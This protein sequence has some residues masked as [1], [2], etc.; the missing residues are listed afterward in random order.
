LL[1]LHFI[2][3]DTAIASIRVI[4]TRC[5]LDF[6]SLHFSQTLFLFFAAG[7]AG[8]LNA[9]AGGGSFI[10]FP[11]LLFVGV[12]PVQANATNTVALWPGLAASTVAYIKRLDAPPRLLIPLLVTS[13]A[14]G[15]GGALL[16]LK[17]PQ[18]TFLHFVPWLILSGTLLFAFGNMIRTI[19][20]TSAMIDDLW[21][22]S[23]RAITVSSFVELLVATYGGYFGAGIGFITLGMLAALGMRDIN[24]MGAIRTLLAAAINA[25]AVVTF[26]LAGAVWWQD[27]AVMVAGALLG[28]WF[29]AHYAQK[30]DPRKVRAFVIA[31]GVAMSAYFFLT[32]R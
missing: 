4:I 1:I 3:N 14:G 31:V 16:L 17:T 9:L 11:A 21:K 22:I 7:I 13:V 15:W 26:I 5:S 12:P 8:T 19:A 23:W 20:G 10:S 2:L 27:C 32:T 24:A 29:G 25:A 30:A 6:M 18:R 28:G